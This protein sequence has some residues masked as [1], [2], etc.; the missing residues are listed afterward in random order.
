MLCHIVKYRVLVLGSSGGIG[1]FAVQVHNARDV[2]ILQRFRSIFHIMTVMVFKANLIFI[3]IRV[4]CMGIGAFECALYTVCTAVTMMT[5]A[6][7]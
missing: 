6:S 5:S 7:N 1:T 2:C 3:H 4:W